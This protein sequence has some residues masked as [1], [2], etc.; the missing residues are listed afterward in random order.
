MVQ[1]KDIARVVCK[2]T[3]DI[4]KHVVDKLLNTFQLGAHCE[5]LKRYLLLGQVIKASKSTEFI[6]DSFFF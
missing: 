1:M 6:W 3:S 2:A 4:D 5:A